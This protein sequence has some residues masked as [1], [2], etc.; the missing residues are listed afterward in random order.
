[1]DRKE[2]R[3]RIREYFLFSWMPE[4]N[5]ARTVAAFMIFSVM[6]HF[7]GFYLFQVEY[8]DPIRP[9]IRPDSI[10]LLDMKNPDARTFLER[11]WDRVVFLDPAS[12]N[13]SARLR[14]SDYAVPFVPSFAEAKP[15]LKRSADRLD[16]REY[17]LPD[18]PLKTGSDTW[19]N[20]VRFSENLA[21]RGVSPHSI[22]DDYLNLVPILPKLRINLTVLSNGVPQVVSV[23]GEGLE[24]NKEILAEAIESTLR[25]APVSADEGNSPGWMELGREEL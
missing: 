5:T 14:V 6:I 2:K 15:A 11:T 18:P 8:P 23:I 22:L 20:P 3:R 4:K 1:M 10:T 7:V 19:S 9:R 13:S 24:E 25:F 12:S 16:Q 21:K 17:S